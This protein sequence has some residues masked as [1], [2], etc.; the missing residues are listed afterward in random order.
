MK[1]TINQ[2]IITVLLMLAAM[3]NFTACDNDPV[4]PKNENEDPLHEEP[5]K[6]TVQLVECHL[7]ADWYKI[8]EQGG[9]HQNPVNKAKYMKR[10]QEITY[11]IKKKEGWQLAEGSQKALYVQQNGEYK[12]GKNFTPAP[13]YL[14]FIKYYNSAGELM[15]EQFFQDGQENIHQ[16]FFTPVNI[17]PTFDGIQQEGDDDP[18]KQIDYIYADTTPWNKSQHDGAKITG[19]E[20]PMGFK[21][22]I[23]F[24]RDRKEFDLRLRLYHG[25]KSKI[26]P[27]TKEFS[28]FYLPSSYLIQNGT[29]DVDLNIPVIVFWSRQDYVD[30]DEDA[31]V[32]KIPED[33]LDDDSNRII[34]SIMH[35]F[36]LS[37]T[38]ALQE[39]I[40]YTYNI[41]DHDSGH[42]W[43]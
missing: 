11:E 19:R 40:D 35:T 39:F 1:K 32:T 30:V 31:D 24:L 18:L 28:P 8:Q 25:Y 17:R 42:I 13:V 36:K 12:T 10:V 23:R 4:T 21:G 5:V 33:S 14:V 6:V 43:L 41:G 29:W 15:N 2:V 16:H 3:L 38:E 27:S 22:V 26:D 37:W 34:H 20:N 7:H 9:P